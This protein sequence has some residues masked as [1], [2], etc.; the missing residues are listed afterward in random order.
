M[1]TAIPKIETVINYNIADTKQAIEYISSVVKPQDG[2][3]FYRKSS[4]E[5]FGIYEFNI[6]HID[7][8]SGL[9]SGTLSVSVNPNTDTTTNISV[10]AISASQGVLDNSRVMDVQSHFLKLLSSKLSGGVIEEIT[11]QRI[12]SQPD[13]S[14]S[15]IVVI[16]FIVL[17]LVI[18]LAS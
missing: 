1:N 3:G 14:A 16:V 15:I 7:P 6:L 5:M 17:V 11:Q 9:V 2:N 8:I 4:N 13:H 18:Y 10:S 12:E